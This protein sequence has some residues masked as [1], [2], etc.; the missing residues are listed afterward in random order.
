M[1]RVLFFGGLLMI[2][3]WTV[4][5]FGF[6]AS[7]VIHIL[8]AIAIVSLTIRLFYNKSLME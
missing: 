6:H 3:A 4:G 1:S 2:I 8:L 5:Y 7:G